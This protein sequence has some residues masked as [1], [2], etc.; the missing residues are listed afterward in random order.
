MKK[1]EFISI[2]MPTRMNSYKSW[3]SYPKKLKNAI[4]FNTWLQ[5]YAFN[6]LKIHD[7]KESEVL[8]RNNN[9]KEKYNEVCRKMQ[10]K[11]Q[12]LIAN[13]TR[14]MSQSYF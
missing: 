14:R 2:K 3:Q 11:E 4:N 5:K 8:R 6:C 13:L 9:F 12:A 10:F 7:I 1:L